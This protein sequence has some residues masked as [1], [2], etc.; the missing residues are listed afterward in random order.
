MTSQQDLKA[1]FDRIAADIHTEDD[2]TALRDVLKFKGDQ[3]VVQ[4]G[5]RTAWKIQ[6]L[7]KQKTLRQEAY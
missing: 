3:Y 6:K 4:L 7:K 2:I 5:D 1:I